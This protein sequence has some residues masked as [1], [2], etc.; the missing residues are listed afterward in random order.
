M[1]S[2]RL[3][4]LR[5]FSEKTQKQI[6]DFLG[7]TRQGY[8]SYENGITEP[9]IDTIQKLANYFNVTTDYL[10]GRSDEVFKPIND[11]ETSIAFFGRE[12]EKLTEEESRHLEESLEMFRALKAKRIKEQDNKR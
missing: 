12:K 10:L 8:G 1:L 3:R 9:D 11:D 4:Q 6:A 7:I 2:K 5:I